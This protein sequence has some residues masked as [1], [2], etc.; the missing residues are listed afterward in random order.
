MDRISE[1]LNEAMADLSGHE[2]DA[3]LK[4]ERE[5]ADRQQSAWKERTWRTC[6][7]KVAPV[8]A[9]RFAFDGRVTAAVRAASEWLEKGAGEHL[10]LRGGTGCG[11]S[12]AAC[13]VV[14]ALCEPNLPRE[15]YE[16][17]SYAA[18]TP[19]CWLTPDLFVSAVMHAYEEESPRL[20]K[21][22]IIDDVGREARIDLFS[23]ALCRIL[24]S[25]AHRLLMTTNLR[26]DQFRDR[27]QDKRLIDRMNETCVAI[28]I[29]DVSMRKQDGDF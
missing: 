19:V 5:R 22:V 23:E 28:E 26:K 21:H 27:Y 16:L 3:R 9:A 7:T 4:A 17:L 12:V 8:R 6:V 18:R 11:K 1:I 24:D 25:S 15:R 14:K 13:F 20:R 10:M 2:D 29:P